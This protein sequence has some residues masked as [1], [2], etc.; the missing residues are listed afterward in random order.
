MSAPI[1]PGSPASIGFAQGAVAAQPD[2]TYVYA[3]GAL[4]ETVPAALASTAFTPTT[5]TLYLW[6]V[7]LGAGTKVS[8][9]GLVTSTTAGAT[10]THWWTCL[11]DQNYTVQA[12]SADQTSGAI[13]ASTWITLPMAAAYTTTYS[14][15]YYLGVMV[16]ATTMP[17]LCGTAA[18]PLVALITGTGSPVT[19]V[20]GASNTGAT[21]A[22]TPGA[23]VATT[24]TA[25]AAIP[26][27]YCS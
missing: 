21:T 6:A 14:G 13:A 7:H 20:G 18:A 16:A 3:P 2:S 23:S 26:Y 9:V 10:I 27:L 17:T 4:T 24:P 12:T 22:L 11:V 25:T 1:T 5:G 8:N 19:K 15:L